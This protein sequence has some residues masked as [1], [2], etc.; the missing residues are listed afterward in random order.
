MTTTTTTTTTPHSSPLAAAWASVPEL[1]A[2]EGNV[3]SLRERLNAVPRGASHIDHVAQIAAGI[4]PAAIPA[5]IGDRVTEL[6]RLAERRTNEVQV[7]GLAQQRAQDEVNE[8]RRR[9]APRALAALQGQFA[10][11]IATARVDVTALKGARTAEDAIGRKVTAAWQA[12]TVH[13]GQLRAIRAA[14]RALL[15]QIDGDP[16]A[17]TVLLSEAA[18]VAEWIDLNPWKARIESGLDV[19]AEWPDIDEDAP[20]HLRW[21]LTCGLTPT[22]PTLQ[23]LRTARAE[24]REL[25]DH[26]DSQ[27]RSRKPREDGQLSARE[28]NRL[29]R[30]VTAVADSR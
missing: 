2:A 6:D 16:H 24:Q 4:D 10:E 20:G 23:D 18:P 29:R 7:L 27:R 5:D 8:I 9:Q 30:A 11:Q 21:L 1:A 28:L 13:A 17:V 12:V 26:A 25:I 22:L 19:P 15:T 3:R 14:H